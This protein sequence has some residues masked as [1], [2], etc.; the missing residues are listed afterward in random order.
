MKLS[1]VLF[2]SRAEGNARLS[3]RV[4]HIAS[5]SLPSGDL[6]NQRRG[7]GSPRMLGLSRGLVLPRGCDRRN[8]VHGR[9]KQACFLDDTRAGGHVGGRLR[10]H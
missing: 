7:A 6:S 3:C 10:V 1:H 9:A 8:L 2:A 5:R 4:D